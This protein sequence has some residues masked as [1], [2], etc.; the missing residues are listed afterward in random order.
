MVD[1]WVLQAVYTT[2]LHELWFSLYHWPT[3]AL[4]QP[5]PRAYTS[6][7]SA[8]T[9]GLH[10]LWFSLYHWPIRPLVQPVPR[11]Y[12]TFGSACTTGPHELWFSLYHWPTRALVQPVPLA[13]TTFGSA[14]TTD[15]HELWLFGGSLRSRGFRWTFRCKKGMTLRKVKVSWS[16]RRTGGKRR[17]EIVFTPVE[18][19]SLQNLQKLCGA[20]EGVITLHLFSKAAF[21]RTPFADG[22]ENGLRFEQ[23]L[24]RN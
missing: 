11:A 10:E 8:C 5:V 16:H 6:F 21:P 20:D 23:W 9:T 3:R 4:V 19:N 13:C 18:Q 17:C 12:T 24:F 7:G 15:L 22:P 14:C 2:G 1:Q